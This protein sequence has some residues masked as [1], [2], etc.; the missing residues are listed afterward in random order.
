MRDFTSDTN[1]CLAEKHWGNVGVMSN[2]ALRILDLEPT[3]NPRHMSQ[4]RTFSKLDL[5]WHMNGL[6]AASEALF[7]A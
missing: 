7:I 5:G 4:A 1:F 6:E 2:Y 3:E